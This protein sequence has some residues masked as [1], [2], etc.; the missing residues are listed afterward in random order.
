M[1]RHA[2]PAVEAAAV[3]RESELCAF[4]PSLNRKSLAIAEELRRNGGGGGLI[5]D[6]IASALERQKAKAYRLGEER[7]FR[8]YEELKGCTFTPMIN[9]DAVL[10]H[11][12]P[13]PLPAGVSRHLELVALAKRKAE[14]QRQIEAKVFRTNP[15]GNPNLY[16]VPQPFALSTTKSAS[17]YSSPDTGTYMCKV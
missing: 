1:H 17:R 8:E 5:V 13:A 7:A 14:E 16:T 4:K 2:K 9:K 11:H 15:T 12:L 6:S 10:P 3:D